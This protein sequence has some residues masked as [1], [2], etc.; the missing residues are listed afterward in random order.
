MKEKIL[1][2]GFMV[3]FTAGVLFLGIR[4]FMPL[5]Q[6]LGTE[7]GREHLAVFIEKAGIFAPV[8]FVLLMALQVVIAVIP[9]G[10]LEIT[11]GVLFG[12]WLGTV[13]TIAGAFLGALTVYCLVRKFG[14]PLVNLFVSEERFK[15]FSFLQEEDKLELWIFILFLIPGIPKDLLTYIVPMTKIEG[16]TFLALSTLARFPALT[17]SVLMGDSLS[18]GRYGLC[19]T[20]VVIGAV[21]AFAGFWFR[22]HILKEKRDAK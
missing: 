5:C 22:K 18:E 13:L 12:G 8:V 4:Y 19:L 3:I 9:G 14:R 7:Q 21:A 1:K 17:A 16:K 20:I 11:A 2:Y 10:P 6:L 15:K